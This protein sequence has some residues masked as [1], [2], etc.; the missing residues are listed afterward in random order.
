M[1][2]RLFLVA[3]LLFFFVPV[4]QAAPARWGLALNMETKECAGYWAGDEFVAY[5]L[6]AGWKAYYPTYAESGAWGKIITEAGE[7][8][9]QIRKEEACCMELGYTFVARNIGQGQKEILRD[10]DAFE[11]SLTQHRQSWPVFFR[12]TLLG[13]A[14][15]MV[16]GIIFGIYFIRKRMYVK[17]ILIPGIKNK[18]K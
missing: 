10:R 1:K 18:I 11:K 8:S 12:A 17:K 3:I 6:P 5:H 14:V 2:K 4:C 9:F 13:I 15:L 7:C 16:S